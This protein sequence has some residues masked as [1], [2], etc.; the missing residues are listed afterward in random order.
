M[1]W[2]GLQDMRNTLTC[3]HKA[4]H[5]S[6]VQLYIADNISHQVK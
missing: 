5:C 6:D 2:S 1:S 4:H 3:D